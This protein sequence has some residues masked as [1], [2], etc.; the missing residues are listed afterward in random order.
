[1]AIVGGREAPSVGVDPLG[2]ASTPQP[3]PMEVVYETA[4]EAVPE[5]PGNPYAPLVS[6]DNL[7]AQEDEDEAGGDDEGDEPL[8]EE[9]TGPDPF[10]TPGAPTISSLAEREIGQERLAAR[11]EA[12]QG[13]HRIYIS[14]VAGPGS[15]AEALNTLLAEGLVTAQFIDQGQEESFILYAPS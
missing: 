9:E 8:D 12:L 11:A 5:L 10:V 6:N 7:E 15:L 4:A 14:T 1:V 2:V 13:E 3:A